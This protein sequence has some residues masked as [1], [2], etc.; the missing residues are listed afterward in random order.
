MGDE[1]VL[2]KRVD[3]HEDRLRKLETNSLEMKYELLNINKSQSDLKT[4]FLEQGEKYTKQL[5]K[6]WDQMTKVFQNGNTE[7]TTTEAN[8]DTFIKLFFEKYEKLVIAI[9]VTLSSLAGLNLL[10]VDVV[11]IL[12]K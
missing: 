3:D 4:L 7:P 8:K 5:D 10:G 11:E 1:N 12:T 9:I 6:F 2:E